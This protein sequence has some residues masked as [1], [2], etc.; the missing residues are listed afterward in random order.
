[1]SKEIFYQKQAETIIKNMKKRNFEGYY[2]QNAEEAKQI[3]LRMME[4]GAS[5]SWGGT[6]TMTEIGVMDAIRGGKYRLID[7]AL[8]K[9]PEEARE[10]FAKTVMA[11]Y[12]LMSTNA[13]TL[14]GELINIDGNGNRLACLMQG[15]KNV[16]IVAGMNKVVSDVQSGYQR[17]KDIASPPNAIRLHKNTPCALT[18]HCADC[19]SP[20]CICSHTVITRRC[21]IPGRI[22]VIL[23]GQELGY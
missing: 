12:Y 22:K 17:V 19:Y 6:M 11:D 14:E 9:D 10:I 16:I 20:D 3:V 4:E 23:V 7:R 1:M 13:I 15:P 18:G 5:I 2:A 21:G 8:A